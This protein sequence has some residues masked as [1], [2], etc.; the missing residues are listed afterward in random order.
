[1][2]TA[3][4][5]STLHTDTRSVCI[6]QATVGQHLNIS[7]IQGG[8]NLGVTTFTFRPHHSNGYVWPI[9][10]DELAWS[11]R[12]CVSLSVGHVREPLKNG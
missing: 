11:V 4:T 3:E 7:T 10:I 2:A 9:A 1:M 5:E 8:P 12:L 6:I